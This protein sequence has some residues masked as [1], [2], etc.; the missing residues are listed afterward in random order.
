MR[1]ISKYFVN[2][3]I[4]IVPIVCTVVVIHY[5]FIFTEMLIGSYLPINY[6]G[7]ALLVTLLIIVLVGWL[8]SYWILKRVIQFAEKLVTSIP[9]VKFIYTSLKQ[10]SKAIFES[11]KL[12]QNAVLVPYPS[13]DSKVL[14]FVV[15]K[16]S[17]PITDKL[18]DDHVCVFVPFS[19]NLTAG[20][21][22]ILPKKDI[23]HLD[24]TSESALQ[25]IFTAGVVMPQQNDSNN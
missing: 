24:I 6:P 15:S 21:N 17:K 8:S 14:G 4:V 18:G 23:I 9:I 10:F 11:E 1:L 5:V 3:L 7:L 22:I 20:V 16:L 12:F 19:L 13:P 25:Y 2:G